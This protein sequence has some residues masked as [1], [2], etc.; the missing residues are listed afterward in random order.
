MREN[1][2]DSEIRELERRGLEG[3]PEAI[4]RLANLVRRVGGGQ[5]NV[6][7]ADLRPQSVQCSARAV[8]N[9]FIN[10]AVDGRQSADATGPKAKDG[11]FSLEIIQR[12][13]GDAVRVM[14][15]EGFANVD[16]RGHGTLSLSVDGQK[17]FETE[18]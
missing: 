12:D 16:E 7:G 18:R 10:L 13:R 17:V 11:G 15:I 5:A 8:R 1:S 3:D 2:L 6:G 4:T 14:R 9:W